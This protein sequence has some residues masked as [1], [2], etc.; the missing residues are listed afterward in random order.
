MKYLID[1]H[2]ARLV[3]LALATVRS[4]FTAQVEA[5][6]NIGRRTRVLLSVNL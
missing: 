2:R 3:A 6:V 5:A 4:R 1:P